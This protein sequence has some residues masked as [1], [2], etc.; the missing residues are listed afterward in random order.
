MSD[1]KWYAGF[2]LLV[3]ALCTIWGA[4]LWAAFS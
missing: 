1:W 4:M 2:S 3:A